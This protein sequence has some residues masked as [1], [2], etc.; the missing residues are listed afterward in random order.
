M[1]IIIEEY[2]M[3]AEVGGSVIA[4]ATWAGSREWIVAPWPRYFTC[5]EVITVFTLAARIA[6]GH[7]DSD[8][9][10]AAWCGELR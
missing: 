9:F 6:A 4:A 2:S 10:P 8:P 3:T 1:A 5:N 7:R